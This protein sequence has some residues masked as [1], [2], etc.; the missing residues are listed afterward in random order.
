VRTHLSGFL[1]VESD[2]AGLHLIARLGPALATRMTDR[3]VEQIAASATVV[4]VSLSRLHARRP[5][6]QGL[7]LGYAAFDESEIER[8]AQQL[9]ATL[10]PVLATAPPDRLKQKLRG[11]AGN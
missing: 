6:R 3:D 1:E 5:A 10:R 11:A 8:A 2:P 4:T 7:L 9:A